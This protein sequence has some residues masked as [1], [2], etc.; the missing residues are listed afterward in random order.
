MDTIRAIKTDAIEDLQ[1]ARWYIGRGLMR[2]GGQVVTPTVPGK[3]WARVPGRTDWFIMDI[4]R[5][6]PDQMA[7]FEFKP[8]Q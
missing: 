4:K 6:D 2:R 8:Y 5:V 7:G 1:K 3:Y